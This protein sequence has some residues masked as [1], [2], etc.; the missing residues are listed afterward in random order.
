MQQQQFQRP[1]SVFEFSKAVHALRAKCVRIVLWDIWKARA[2][3]GKNPRAVPL[4]IT[5]AGT[6][7]SN[8]IAAQKA[9]A[10]CTGDTLTNKEEELVV[11]AIMTR[12]YA[13]GDLEVNASCR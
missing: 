12:A 4:V 5:Q 8:V 6:P 7:V 11:S 2:V 3:R 13:R 9:F 10:H 1:N